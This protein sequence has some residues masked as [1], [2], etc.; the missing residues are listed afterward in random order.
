ML[1]KLSKNLVICLLIISRWTP[2]SRFGSKILNLTE[3]TAVF[4]RNNAQVCK[5]QVLLRM[6]EFALGLCL[7]KKQKICLYGVGIPTEAL[8]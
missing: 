5:R 6:H 3:Q 1:A 7:I 8:G 4:I 2:E